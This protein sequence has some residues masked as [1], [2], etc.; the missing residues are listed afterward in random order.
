MCIPCPPQ[1]RECNSSLSC[2]ACEFRFVLHDGQCLA[3]CSPGSYETDDYGCAPCHAA[4]ATCRGPSSDQCV[5]C[6][7]NRV[8]H[9]GKCLDQCP[10]QYW[11]ESVRKQCLPCPPGCDTCHL[12]DSGYGLVC[13]R[14]SPNWVLDA[15]TRQCL[16]PS[17]NS[18]PEGKLFETSVSPLP[19]NVLFHPFETRRV[20]S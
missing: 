5:T 15:S 12:Q 10:I 7:E 2:T 18:C 16:N 13:T 11:N 17:I 9:D 14:C 6:A 19:L 3:S 4:C 8:E 1:C 20:R